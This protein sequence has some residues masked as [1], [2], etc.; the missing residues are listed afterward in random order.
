MVYS[1]CH[2]SSKDNSVQERQLSLEWGVLE[3]ALKNGEDFGKGCRGNSKKRHSGGFVRGLRVFTY[4]TQ[5]GQ[6]HNG[7]C[8]TLSMSLRL[9]CGW[10]FFCMLAGV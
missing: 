7:R 2:S 1:K 8:W 3:W 5:S 10:V 6:K 4:G 9:M